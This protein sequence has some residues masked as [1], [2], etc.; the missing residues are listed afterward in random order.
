MMEKHLMSM[1]A[2]TKSRSYDQNQLKLLCD[3]L[4]DRIEDL[5]E[6]FEIEYKQNSDS[7]MSM[8][9][10][11]HEGD[12]ASALNIYYEGDTYRGNWKCRTQGCDNTFKSSIIGFIRGV[13]SARKYGW[14]KPGDKTCSFQE[15][16]DF[17]TEF[18]G[19]DLDSY[20]VSKISIE[21]KKFAQIVKNVTNTPEQRKTA[22]TRDMVKSS[23]QIPAKYYLNRGYSEEALNKYD[24]GLCGNP[25]KEMS[26][27]VVAPVY[28]DDHNFVVGCTGRSV[29]NKCDKCGC[30]HDNEC[31]EDY[32]KWL[33]SK[34]RHS[35]GFKTQ[36]HLY[37]MWF[38]KSH[39]QETNTV[40]IVESP[41]NV[42]KLEE[43]GIHNSVA[44]FGTNLSDRQK[45]LLDGSGAMNLIVIMDNDEAGKK[46]T[47]NI[48]EK[49][50]RTYQVHVPTISKLDIGEMSPEEI[51]AE[52]TNFVQRISI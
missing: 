13:L 23:L 14:E 17:A 9:C 10:P 11:I 4:C 35:S 30:Y 51:D 42:W 20:H 22:I 44:I 12:N 15:A 49:C 7:M 24:V 1:T 36:N 34:W 45:I 33:H 43:N 19:T 32:N 28:D 16:I 3:A 8:C 21:K 29:F 47:A 27:R 18:V 41:G 52:I 2:K 5:L 40:I 39:I 37:N 38:A 46:A 6:Y 50:N 25:N 26:N 31:P 48:I